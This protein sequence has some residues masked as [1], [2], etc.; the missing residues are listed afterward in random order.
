MR[1]DK[2]RGLESRA[3]AFGGLSLAVALEVDG[4]FGEFAKGVEDA[5]I[6]AGFASELF[7]QDG[8][9]EL[10]Q[11]GIH[12]GDGDAEA[13]GVDRCAIFLLHDFV[14]EIEAETHFF[15]PRLIAEPVLVA[16]GFPA[17]EVVNGDGVR[18]R[19]VSRMTEVF[20]DFGVGDTVE[21]HGV[22]EFAEF[23]GQACDFAGSAVSGGGCFGVA[24]VGGARRLYG[25]MSGIHVGCGVCRF[26]FWLECSRGTW[27][28]AVQVEKMVWVRRSDE[29]ARNCRAK[30]A[31]AL[32]PRCGKAAKD[33]QRMAVSIVG[34]TGE[35]EPIL[36]G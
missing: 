26:N 30:E 28:K 15:E 29:E 16:T 12:A 35:S 17:G 14:G 18:R 34:S 23:F 3:K 27:T 25:T 2:R 11:Q 7:A 32:R 4:G 13:G 22:D 9:V 10:H 20:D 6:G 24:R 8:R 33:D 36:K 5:G 19:R 21:E 1:G 31:A